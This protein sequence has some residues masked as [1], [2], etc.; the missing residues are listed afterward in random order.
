MASR[1]DVNAICPDTRGPPVGR[2]R[3][4]GLQ[5][6][7]SRALYADDTQLYTVVFREMGESREVSLESFMRLSEWFMKIPAWRILEVKKGGVSVY[8]A[9]RRQDGDSQD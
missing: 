9:K 1:R 8:S 3:K 4:S 7:L 6:V 2:G 5:E